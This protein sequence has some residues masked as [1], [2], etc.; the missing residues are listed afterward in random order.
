MVENIKILGIVKWG[1]N[2]LE[3]I[4]D[5]KLITLIYFEQFKNGKYKL[6]SLGS[7]GWGSGKI[8]VDDEEY[9]VYYNSY[10][11]EDDEK[12]EDFYMLTKI[13]KELTLEQVKVAFK[14]ILNK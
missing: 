11:G 14:N 12:N 1:S 5:K 6:V 4:G 8:K 3:V 9:I 7:A 10:Q 13:P 2:L